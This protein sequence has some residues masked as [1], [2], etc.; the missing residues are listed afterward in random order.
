MRK[1]EKLL[2]VKLLDNPTESEISKTILLEENYQLFQ[3]FL[4]LSLKLKGKESKLT[5]IEIHHV[6]VS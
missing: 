4:N 1:E 3:Q 2:R 5:F 6:P